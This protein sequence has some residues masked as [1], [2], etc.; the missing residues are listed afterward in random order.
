MNKPYV[1]II[2]PTYNESQ[3]IITLIHQIR[4]ILHNESY[5]IIVVDDRSTDGTYGMVRKQLK[6]LSHIRPFLHKGTRDLGKSILLG[7]KQAR[8]E[9]IIGMD[10]DFNHDPRVLPRLIRTIQ[11]CDLVVADR[12]IKG[13][14]M[15]DKHTHVR[16][17]LFNLM[18]RLIFGFPIMD[19]T[20]GYYAIAK[21]DLIKLNLKRIYYGYGEYHMRL[22]YLAHTNGL[23]MKTVPVYYRK[24]FFGVSK[25]KHMKMFFSY[26]KTACMLSLQRNAS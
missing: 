22:V 1:S 8:G 23:H 11:S 19:N 18:L 15:E 2:I 21:K 3:N 24:R 10:A 7:I 20:S 25:S 9:I 17:Y 14:G 16:S 4:T 12:F 5:E 13:G 26:L 6:S